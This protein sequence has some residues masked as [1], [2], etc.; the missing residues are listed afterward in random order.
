MLSRTVTNGL[1]ETAKKLGSDFDYEVDGS[2]TGTNADGVAITK[3]GI[4]CAVIS[5]PEKN[6]HTQTEIVSLEDIEN[7]AK[8]IAGYLLGGAS[9]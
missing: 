1:I 7:T 4:P 9:K 8:I 3:G 6:M 5:V 2:T